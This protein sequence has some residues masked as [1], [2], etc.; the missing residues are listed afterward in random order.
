M[1]APGED[2]MVS[3]ADFWTRMPFFSN[4]LTLLELYSLRKITSND[5]GDGVFSLEELPAPFGGIF[6]RF[7]DSRFWGKTMIGVQ[8]GLER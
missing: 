8:R 1:D 2:G 7:V 6:V 5:T 4:S 3:D